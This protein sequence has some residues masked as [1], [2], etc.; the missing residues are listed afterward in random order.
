M[1]HWL[2]KIV[3]L[4]TEQILRQNFKNFTHSVFILLCPREPQMSR[5]VPEDAGF[6]RSKAAVLGENIKETPCIIHRI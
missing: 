6:L 4:V 5:N 3:Y 2:I 1:K